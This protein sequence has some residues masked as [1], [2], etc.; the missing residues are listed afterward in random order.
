MQQPFR[1][2]Q[3]PLILTINRQT[4]KGERMAARDLLKADK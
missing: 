1:Y 4:E 3:W 2:L